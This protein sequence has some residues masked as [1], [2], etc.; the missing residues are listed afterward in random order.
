[1]DKL[2]SLFFIEEEG[3]SLIEY[4]LLVSLIA[5]VVI[6]GLQLFG[7]SVFNSLVGSTDS[8]SAAIETATGGN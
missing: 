3:A 7:F 6:V 1:M 4:G 8:V 5:V 2:L